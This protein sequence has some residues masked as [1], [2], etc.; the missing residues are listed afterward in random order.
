MSIKDKIATKLFGEKRYYPF[1]I[2]E[3]GRTV[4]PVSENFSDTVEKGISG[5]ITSIL[6]RESDYIDLIE[7]AD[8]FSDKYINIKVVTVLRT[9]KNRVFCYRGG[10]YCPI[11]EV[12]HTD[13][14]NLF[15]TYML[16][17]KMFMLDTFSDTRLIEAVQNS[18]PTFK[19]AR[20]IRT[21]KTPNK[22][23][24]Y[25]LNVIVIDDKIVDDMNS[26]WS[27]WFKKDYSSDKW[28][29]RPLEKAHFT[30]DLQKAVRV[31]MPL[32]NT[33][34]LED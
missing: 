15:D 16:G 12:S 8:G 31:Q 10:I 32:V 2:S 11:Q 27:S 9:N 33:K 26:D 17:G 7:S 34:E 23:E 18:I 6:L 28:S 21:G 19:G 22:K 30:S 3:P 5:N 14:L 1:V 4:F 25:L 13:T 20:I 29:F 24:A